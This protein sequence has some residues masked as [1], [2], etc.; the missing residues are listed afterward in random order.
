MARIEENT[1]FGTQKWKPTRL[2]NFSKDLQE[3]HNAEFFPVIEEEFVVLEIDL[4]RSAVF[5]VA[6]VPDKFARFRVEAIDVEV[7]RA[8]RGHAKGVAQRIANSEATDK[9]AGFEKVFA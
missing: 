7:V 5:V 2:E 6:V 8:V 9:G 3:F 4:V 1:S